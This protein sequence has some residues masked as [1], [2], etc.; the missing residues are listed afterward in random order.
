[1]GI[2]SS[3]SVRILVVAAG[4][5]AAACGSHSQ[6]PPTGPT[7]DPPQIACPLDVTVS[8]VP[9]ASQPVTYSAPVVSKGAAPVN[10]VCSPVSGA[11]FPLGST[12]V[13]CAATD[14]QARQAACAFKVTLKGFAVSIKTYDAYG[15]SLTEGEMGNPK[16]VQTIIDPTATYPVFLQ[17]LFDQTYPGQGLVVINRGRSGDPV[18]SLDPNVTNTTLNVIKSTVATDKPGAVLLL[19]GYNNLT[20]PCPTGRTSAQACQDAIAFVPIGLRDCIRAVRERSPS[21]SFIFLSTLTPPGPNVSGSNRID[22]NA[23]VQTNDKIKQLAT[24]ERVVLVD[25]YTAFVG[26]EGD[27]VNVDGLHLKSAGYQ[28]L[29]NTF[30]A[31]IQKTVP[32]TPLAAFI[33]PN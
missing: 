28:A 25:S 22:P 30:F 10:T 27:Y 1:V 11:S 4:V 19:S 9:T 24:T 2:V 13:N 15:D 14:A 32:Q 6:G 3:S 16:I 26:H 23:I 20:G 29:A 21:T 7:T 18:E 5:L 12:T 33:F 17:A 8:S 31:S